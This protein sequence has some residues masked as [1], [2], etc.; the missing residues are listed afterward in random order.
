MLIPKFWAEARRHQRR[1][2]R[3]FTVRRQGWSDASQEAAQL[4]ADQR[5]DEAIARIMAGED[6]PR[7]EKRTSYG[8]EGVPIREEV[9]SWHGESAVTRNIYGARCLNTPKAFFVDVDF[10]VATGSCWLNI[11]IA[12]A[13]IWLSVKYL[14]LKMLFLTVPAAF[15][16]ST[17][18]THFLEVTAIALRG[19]SERIARS[20][21]DKVLAARDLW[22][23]RVYR[24]PAGFRV[25][26]MHRQFA[27]DDPEVD[28]VFAA[29]AADGL[30]ALMCKKQQCFRARVSP[31]PWRMGMEKMPPQRKVWPI[32]E[33]DMP[34]RL[35]WI[36]RYEQAATGY[37]ACQFV[38]EFGEGM[39][40]GNVAVVQRLHDH[41]CQAESG[42]P[43]A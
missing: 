13:L 11:V 23:W 16:A 43:L 12:V 9:V 18:V 22:R 30:Y 37:A 27:P 2:T 5:A 40:D 38:G 1:D 31:K 17:L 24:T 7:R 29:L 28:E 19:G 25:L 21:I 36:D 14:P 3:R 4:H 35:E 34:R 33:I 32:P 26:M 42:L 39:I 41:L 10:A 20:R 6:L 8:I 15:T